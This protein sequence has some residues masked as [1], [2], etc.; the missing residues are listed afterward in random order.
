M[1][2][3]FDICP[4]YFE[5]LS[6]QIGRPAQTMHTGY[7]C[8]NI[9]SYK[10]SLFF[11]LSHTLLSM[12]WNAIGL[13]LILQGKPALGPTATYAA[14]VILLVLSAGYIFSSIKDHPAT[15]LLLACIGFFLAC[16]AISGALTRDRDLWPSEYWRYAGMAINA[17]GVIGFVSAVKM[18]VDRK[19]S[20]KSL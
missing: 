20:S 14:I 6:S 17:L 18:F 1:E 12:L 4:G 3:P 2:P 7:T 19:R 16:Y 8:M 11:L 15:Y 5:P 13:W 10:N 9:G